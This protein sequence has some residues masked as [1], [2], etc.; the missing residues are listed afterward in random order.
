MRVGLNR[1]LGFSA[2]DRSEN[3]RRIGE[4]AAL[5]A[6]AGHIAI[7]AFISPMERDRQ[8]ARSAAGSGFHEIYVRADLATCEKRDPKGLYKRARAGEIAEFTGISAPY[9][10]PSNP[11]LILDT[12]ERDLESCVNELYAYVDKVTRAVAVG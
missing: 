10:A 2:G 8:L 4:V 11:E 3:I 9:E 6:D 7:A 5:F 12:G 1:D